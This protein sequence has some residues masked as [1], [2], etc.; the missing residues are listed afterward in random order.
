MNEKKI[1]RQNATRKSV[2]D[3]LIAA[4]AK[5][6]TSSYQNN[7][8][9]TPEKIK[10]LNGQENKRP[11]T[12]VKNIVKNS[13][14][15]KRIK[16]VDPLPAVREK[17]NAPPYRLIVTPDWFSQNSKDIDVSIIVPCYKSAQFIAEQ[18]ASWDLK[19]DDGLKKEIIYV[20]DFCP[21]KSYDSIIRSWEKRRPELKHGIGKIIQTTS[22]G[23]FANACNLGAKYASGKHLVFLNADITL[24]PNWIKPLW[25]ALSDPTIGIVGNLHLKKN[26]TI[27]SC[28]SEWD[29]PTGS[30]VHVGKFIYK[31]K[32]INKPF[33]P[34]TAPAELMTPH[35]VEMVTG[36]CFMISRRLF[37]EVKGFDVDYRIGYWEDADLCM[38]VQASGYRIFW[39]PESVIYHHGNHS[40]SGAHCHMADNKR[41]F[42][43]KWVRTKLI[44]TFS[45][46][47]TATPLKLDNKDIVVYTAIT[48]DYDAIKEQPLTARNVDF[49]AFTESLV[50]S[51]TWQTRPV[52]KLFNDP[53]RNAKIHKI[54]PHVYFPDKEYSLWIDGSVV[55]DFTFPVSRLIEMYLQDCDLAVFEHPDRH[56]VYQEANACLVRKLD[57]P[58][59][60]NNQVQRYTKEGYPANFGLAECSVLLRRHTDK[61]KQFNEAWWEEIKNGSKRDQISFNY[62]ANKLNLKYNYFPGDLRRKN[63]LFIR[64]NHAKS[65]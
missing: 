15:R 28:G 8:G 23:G 3:K 16:P 25:N 39:T 45:K 5:K 55:I 20:D 37:Q 65:R 61:I 34:E 46:R 47:K 7:Y 29:V 48:N 21:Q 49:V 30:F 18:I 32:H 11:N 9:F 62:V 36:A 43:D 13:K 1:V 38:K 4:L 52:H 12:P 42:H 26:G 40:Q 64:N 14:N 2:Q 22:N 58:I 54:L 59:I 24:T 50:E 60:I 35:D 33:T 44:H 27:D 57:D 53:N 10:Q 41:I 31:K 56:C 6:P 19:T 51:T 17:F 63:Y